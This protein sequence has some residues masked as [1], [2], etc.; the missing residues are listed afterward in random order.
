MFKLVYAVL[1]YALLIEWS[2]SIT[3]AMLLFRALWNFPF[4]Y[5][6]ECKLV[7]L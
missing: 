6:S 5:C 7:P 2:Y 1:Y 3:F 4:R